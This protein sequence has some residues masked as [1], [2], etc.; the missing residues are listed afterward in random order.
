M[1]CF[2][3]K[4]K[5]E[6]VFVW[7]GCIC[8][9]SCLHWKVFRHLDWRY[10]GKKWVIAWAWAFAWRCMASH[11]YFIVCLLSLPPSCIKRCIT[12]TVSGKSEL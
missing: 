5:E 6:V 3:S 4:E 7:G 11:H 9:M 12:F 10:H 8:G 1:G 2:P